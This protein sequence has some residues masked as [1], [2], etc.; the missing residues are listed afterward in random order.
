[1]IK[2]KALVK[3]KRKNPYIYDYGYHFTKESLVSSI[4]QN[5][6]RIKKDNFSLNK[7]FYNGTRPIYLSSS[8]NIKNLSIGSRDYLFNKDINYILK[9]NIKNLNQE[10]D[11]NSLLERDSGFSIDNIIYDGL[12]IK[13]NK[14]SYVYSELIP[15]IFYKSYVDYYDTVID[16][17]D[18]IKYKTKIQ[19]FSFNSLNKKPLLKKWFEIYNSGNV[20]SGGIPLIDFK[21]NEQLAL[22]TIITTSSMAICENIP[23]KNIVDYWKVL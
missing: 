16:E 18:G 20:N 5:G 2:R 21:N 11:L 15:V 13:N 12:K 9:I 14:L 22:D 23:S 17:E 7:L 4:L 1:M 19:K 8:P 10:V 3:K 6:I